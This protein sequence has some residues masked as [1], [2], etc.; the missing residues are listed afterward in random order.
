MPRRAKEL[1]AIEIR[2]ASHPGKP[3]RNIWIAAGGVAGLILQITPQQAK[4][5]MLR[6]TIGGKRRGIGLGAYPEVGIAEA[7]DRARAAK[8]KIMEGIDPVEERRAARAALAAAQRRGLKFAAALDEYIKAKGPQI[9]NEKAVKYLRNSF[10]TYVH[11]HIGGLQVH[12]VSTQD[13][14]RV[15]HPI[16]AEKSEVARKLRM[17]IEAILSWAAVA[18]HRPHDQPNAARWRG[19][20]A[21]LLPAHDKVTSKVNQPTVAQSDLAAWWAALSERQGIGAEALRFLVLT[22]ARSGEVRGARWEEIDTEAGVWTIPAARMKM[23]REHRIPLSPEA[24][25][26]L[27]ALPRAK[28]NPLVFWGPRGGELSDMVLSQVMRRMQAD[29]EAAALVAGMPTDKAGWRDPR[30][31]RPAVPHGLRS[32]FRDWAAEVG[33]DHHIAE[34]ALAHDVGTEVERAYRRTDMFERRRVVMVAWSDFV[35]GR[36]PK[37]A[38]PLRPKAS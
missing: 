8:A 25:A 38:I 4:S 17:R 19:N 6:T 31:G 1:S 27:D 23:K 12:E 28:D 13:V 16:W 37:G 18:G 30:S 29:A 32:T 36:A 5:W 35:H 7:R 3:D 10:A 9:G 11:P 15:L 24:I 33:V 22:A 26:L 14:L 21:E 2:R 20:L 34:L